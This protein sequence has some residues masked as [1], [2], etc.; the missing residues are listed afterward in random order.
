MKPGRLL[1]IPILMTTLTSSSRADAIMKKTL[2]NGLIWIHQRVQHNQIMAFNLHFPGGSL[3]EP[4][5]KAGLTT[6]MTSVMFKGTK[7]RSSRKIAEEVESLGASLDAGSE[8]DFWE[9]TGQVT[10]DNF[11]K[12][13]GIFRD[14]LLNPIFPQ[15]E[16]EKE[17]QALLNNIRT[18]DERIFNVAFDRFQAEIFGKHPYGRPS[19][20]TE[21]TVLSL[22]RDN[23]AAWHKKE[24]SPKGAIL[25]TVG[26]ITAQTLE[27][28]LLKTFDGWSV[29]G[30]AD[31][32][33]TLRPTYPAKPAS[34]VEKKPFEQSYLMMGYPA[35]AVSDKNY[36]SIKVLNAL[37]G[38]GM[39]SPLFAVVREE[40]GLA[41]EVSSFFPSRRLGSAF[42]VYAGT[43]PKNLEKAQ[44]KIEGMIQDFLAKPLSDQAL[45]DAK[46]YIR[47]HYMMDHQTNRSLAR[48]LGW[49]EL[50]GKNYTYDAHYVEDIQKVT[51]GDV[52]GAAKQLFSQPVTIVKVLSTK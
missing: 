8:E 39:S 32:V 47:G 11:E 41:Y 2:P 40:E 17:K 38:S 7:N 36:A 23:L 35:A 18:K 24:V 34:A 52:K 9:M 26:N 33:S 4:S 48:Y 42:V 43:D 12:L 50:L 22:T 20:G 46:R 28:L 1:L 45:V 29:D 25:V 14:V 44:K 31:A 5:E 30:E 27:K 37:L 3:Q 6:L 13:L 19:E 10:L 49:W 16:F 51:A 15:D 21:P